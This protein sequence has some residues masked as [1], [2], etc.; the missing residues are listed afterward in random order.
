MGRSEIGDNEREGGGQERFWLR[1]MENRKT[2]SSHYQECRGA[3]A[4]RGECGV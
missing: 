1:D 4:E 3:K 2:A